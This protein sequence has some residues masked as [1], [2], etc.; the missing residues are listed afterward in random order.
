MVGNEWKSGARRPVLHDSQR[1]L[2]KKVQWTNFRFLYSTANL[3]YESNWKC[4]FLI[5][6]KSFSNLQR[7]D[8][9][10]KNTIFYHRVIPIVLKVFYYLY[11]LDVIMSY[12]F[13]TFIVYLKFG[14]FY[15]SCYHKLG[16]Y[17]VKSRSISTNQNFE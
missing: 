17:F 12:N 10:I 3:K 13:G 1:F 14:F 6:S 2:Y 5:Q 15:S 4:W 7:W 16:W 11:L 9:W 8:N